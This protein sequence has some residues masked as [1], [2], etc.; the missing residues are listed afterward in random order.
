MPLVIH[1]RVRKTASR[2][3]M[4]TCAAVFAGTGAA[5]AASTGPASSRCSTPTV[6]TP[7][8]DWGDTA[9]YFPV[10][11]GTFP[12]AD[13]G[14]SLQDATLTASAPFNLGGQSLT[15]HAGGSATS[16][17]FCVDRTM[18]DVRFLAQETAP[19]SDLEVDVLVATNSG[20][21]VRSLGTVAD[22]SQPS[23]GPVAPLA[24]R[25]VNLPGWVHRP[26]AVRLSV[27]GQTG[28]W[29]VD[30]VYVDPYRS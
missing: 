22:G 29:Q 6:S 10:P 30:D 24:L 20:Y 27:P 23:W 8:A 17:L 3:A 4:L 5:F 16:P 28:S 7:F 21:L 13:V 18:T 19:G 9:Q 26:V 2:V 11:G 12:S 14:W 25:V 15:I 1:P